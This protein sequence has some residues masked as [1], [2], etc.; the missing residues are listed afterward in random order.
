ME[1]KVDLLPDIAQKHFNWF[2]GQSIIQKRTDIIDRL[3]D[4]TLDYEKC[5]S[6]IEVIFNLCF[7]LIMCF[8]EN[9]YILTPQYEV[10]TK[11]GSRYYLDFAV[12]TDDIKLA[13]E[14]D[15]HEFHEKTADQVIYGNNRDYDLI[16][17]G[18]DVIHFSG[19]EIYNDPFECVKKT[20]R[21][22]EKQ[23]GKVNGELSK[24]SQEDA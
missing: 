9:P 10:I 5:G 18:F 13:V 14:C 6:P 12:I 2:C 15:G 16:M 11:D 7:D 4:M 23:R 8:R 24:T 19:S 22:I 3:M 1:N 21:Y 17:C 20:I